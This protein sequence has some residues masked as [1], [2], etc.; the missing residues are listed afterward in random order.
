MSAPRPTVVRFRYA[1]LGKVRFISHRD[2]ARL[3][4]RAFRQV[5]VPLAYSEGYRPRPRLSFGLALPT[6]ASSDAEFFDVALDPA[7]APHEPTE[8]EAAALA[9]L[10]DDLPARLSAA[11]P[12]G[13]SVTAAAPLEPG[14]VSL[15]QAITSCTWRIELLDVAVDDAVDRVRRIVAAPELPFE[16]ERKGKLSTSDVRPAVLDL[17]PLGPTGRG[18]EL[19]AHL[20]TKPTS[21][22]PAE[23]VRL[24]GDDVGIGR[25]HRTHQWM[26]I[27]DLRS[28]PLAAASVSPP[29]ASNGP[30][31]R[32]AS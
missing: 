8:A 16:R 32:L 20:A 31:L 14:S 22:R 5:K 10:I 21:L 25:V 19:E 28:E 13:L 7:I 24:L 9:T 15:Q 11:L 30:T 29:E 23:L 27:D 18:V 17:E 2:L 26:T 6:A 1:E 3:M 4:E 12:D